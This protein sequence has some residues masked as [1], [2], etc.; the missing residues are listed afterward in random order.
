VHVKKRE[1]RSSKPGI[2]ET[3][4]LV[5]LLDEYSASASE[6]LAGAL[7]DNDRGVIVGRRSFGKG[8]VQEQFSLSNGG[9]VRLTVA[10]YFTPTGRSIQKPYN[11]DARE[12]RH[13]VLKRFDTNDSLPAPDSSTIRFF[14][15]K[16]GKKV[17]DG[18]GI[19]PDFTVPPDTVAVPREAWGLYN[20][21]L[22][23]AYSFQM[24]KRQQAQIGTYKSAAAYASGYTLPPNA[25]T[26]LVSKA[27]ADSL[28]SAGNFAQAE[29][30]L[31][32]RLKALMARYV[33]R[34][35][36]YYQVMNQKDPIVLR[37]LQYLS[38]TK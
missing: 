13:E 15:T 23:S 34:N 17:Y 18:G 11:G 26:G 20:Q 31:N 32:Q 2:F 27:V 3:G 19:S 28:V 30:P 36:G 24:F 8:L 37:A 7:Q 6:V 4:P 1:T 9:A 5:I 21:N 16:G 14:T 12:Y 38:E 22:L 29:K 10:R 25:F 33:W 35:D